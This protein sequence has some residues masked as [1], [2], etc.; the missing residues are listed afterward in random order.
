MTLTFLNV[1]AFPPGMAKG[2]PPEQH[3]ERSWVHLDTYRPKLE[4][5]LGDSLKDIMIQAREAYFQYELGKYSP[6]SKAEQEE[7]KRIEKRLK[8]NRTAALYVHG[9]PRKIYTVSEKSLSDAI[10]ALDIV[11]EVAHAAHFR[12][13]DSGEAKGLYPKT[14][15]PIII[16]GFAEYASL[17]TFQPH[18]DLPGIESALEE[19]RRWH[20]EYY[21]LY[22]SKK[23][24]RFH[25]YFLDGEILVPE[26]KRSHR[27][28]AAL[29][30]IHMWL[31]RL[32]SG[33]PEEYYHAAG[34]TF[35]KTAADAGV[36]AKDIIRNPPKD[37]ESII[38]PRE[39]I[40]E[41][42]SC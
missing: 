19:R 6:G 22:N 32:S 42:I 14:L 36:S 30:K 10:L 16:E 41:M 40:K 29:H 13:I 34:Y 25:D 37:I 8:K 4:E 3:V 15:W 21:D 2:I 39:Y 17:E 31:E 27:L 24:Y 28:K 9:P 26:E 38:D 18:Y 33:S 23:V 11:H 1:F 12:M 20:K 5:L 7:R 35:F